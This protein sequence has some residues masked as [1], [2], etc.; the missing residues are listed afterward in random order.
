MG[1]L[2]RLTYPVRKKP[3]RKFLA[4][5]SDKRVKSR[6]VAEP[7]KARESPRNKPTVKAMNPPATTRNKEKSGCRI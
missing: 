5:L 7:P 1:G 2:M 4:G 3:T 6:R